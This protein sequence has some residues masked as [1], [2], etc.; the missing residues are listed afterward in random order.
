MVP[1]HLSHILASLQSS[2]KRFMCHISSPK[3]PISSP[4]PKNCTLSAIAGIPRSHFSYR[5]LALTQDETSNAVTSALKELISWYPLPPI[6]VIPKGVWSNEPNCH[7]SVKT[8]LKSTFS[9]AVNLLKATGRDLSAADEKYLETSPDTSLWLVCHISRSYG[10]S[11]GQI[12]PYSISSAQRTDAD[13]G[14]DD[15]SGRVDGF[16]R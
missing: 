9:D 5:A 8:H 10:R 11:V 13:L 6:Q 4:F 12:L 1:A 15:I 3:I 2:F 14:L 16:P 7:I